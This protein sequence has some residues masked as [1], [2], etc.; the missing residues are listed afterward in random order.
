[1]LRLPRLQAEVLEVLSR[2]HSRRNAERMRKPVEVLT[3][4]GES[5]KA[6]TCKIASMYRKTVAVFH[7]KKVFTEPN[8]RTSYKYIWLHSRKKCETETGLGNFHIWNFFK[9][10]WCFSNIEHSDFVKNNLYTLLATCKLRRTLFESG[11]NAMWL[12]L[13]KSTLPRC[14]LCSRLSKSWKG[15]Q[16]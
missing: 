5:T 15:F 6:S 3:Y 16:Q 1:M 14:N 10:F 7:L 11:A 4:V 9:N 2:N 8:P 13:S 12:A